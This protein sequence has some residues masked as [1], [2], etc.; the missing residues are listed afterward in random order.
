MRKMVSRKPNRKGCRMNWSRAKSRGQ[1]RRK[2]SRNQEIRKPESEVQ[3]VQRLIHRSFS[4]G[5]TDHHRHRLPVFSLFRAVPILL[6][7]LLDLLGDNPRIDGLLD[8]GL[9]CQAL[10]L[11]TNLDPKSSREI[12]RIRFFGLFFTGLHVDPGSL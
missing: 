12:V 2:N 10:Q 9:R 8:E 4:I 5:P 7:Y 1:N 6:E 11:S 3:A